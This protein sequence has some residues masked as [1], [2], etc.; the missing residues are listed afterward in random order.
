[1][2]LNRKNNTC[3]FLYGLWQGAKIRKITRSLLWGLTTS[4][5]SKNVV[6]WVCFFIL[7]SGSFAVLFIA[8][9]ASLV[10]QCKCVRMYTL[11]KNKKKVISW[12]LRWSVSFPFYFLSLSSFIRFVEEKLW[13]KFLAKANGFQLKK[14]PFMV[15]L[16]ECN[17]ARLWLV[18]CNS[19]FQCTVLLLLQLHY[20][21][22][23]FVS[24]IN[25]NLGFWHF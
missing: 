16:W 12:Y 13:N 11:F 3:L 22:Y 5:V 24:Y 10:L 8:F 20:S 19:I 1:M 7:F 21:C 9:F 4:L 14:F 2:R 17:C 23:D 25:L 15:V 18:S 6:R